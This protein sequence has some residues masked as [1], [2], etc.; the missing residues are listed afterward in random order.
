MNEPQ[1][2]HEWVVFA[3]HSLTEEQA[4]QVYEATKAGGPVASPIPLTDEGVKS[5]SVGCYRCMAEAMDAFGTECPG[6][7]ILT[8][9]L[10][11]MFDP[12]PMPV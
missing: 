2:P 10:G 11:E 6:E 4:R 5:I 8:F 1:P 9:R 3:T 12:P 7:E